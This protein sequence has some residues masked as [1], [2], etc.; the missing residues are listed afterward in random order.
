MTRPGRLPVFAIAL[1]T[2]VSGF[3]SPAFAADP[4][5]APAEAVHNLSPRFTPGDVARYDF[6]FTSVRSNTVADGEPASQ[7]FTQ[8]GRLVRRVLRADDSGTSIS[9]TYERVKADVSGG[10]MA[11]KFDS[12]APPASDLDNPFIKSLRLTVGM[13]VTVRLDKDGQIQ[14]IEGNT[15]PA[16]DP[17]DPK[18]PTPPPAQTLVG[19]PM[20][21]RSLL[22]LFTLP[23]NPARVPV[24][25]TWNHSV[26]TA[27][28][29]VGVFTADTVYTLS[30]ADQ[31]VAKID[32]S[33]K[34]KLSPAAGS[35]AV[36]VGMTDHALSGKIQW[37]LTAGRLREYTDRQMVKLKGPD[38]AGVMRTLD[39]EV[40]VTF[41]LVPGDAPASPKKD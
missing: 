8:S 33:G 32:I 9:L 28:P 29:P 31:G 27:Q 18:P 21:R 41:T 5:A 7:T 10:P 39:S 12:D 22:P 14:T 35:S 40:A 3:V 4:P 34:V 19:D 17:K 20:F 11:L 26:N 6:T 25:G 36:D 38:N 13:P 16:P 15:I 1:G 24:G 23:G 37:D 2:A 30:S